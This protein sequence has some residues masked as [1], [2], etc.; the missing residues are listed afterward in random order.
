MRTFNALFKKEILFNK[1]RMQ[2]IRCGCHGNSMAKELFSFDCNASKDAILRKMCIYRYKA[3]QYFENYNLGDETYRLH[4]ACDVPNVFNGNHKA[5]KH[6]F[7]RPQKK[8]HEVVCTVYSSN[9]L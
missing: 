1:Y 4:I 5:K 7:S 3:T 9:G 6:Y 2:I 8:K